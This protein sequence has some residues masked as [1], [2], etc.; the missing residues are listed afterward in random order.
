MKR[1]IRLV[2][3]WCAVMFVLVTWV[4]RDDL[5]ADETLVEHVTAFYK[6]KGVVPASKEALAVFERE[7]NL[8]PVALSFRKLQVSES[9]PG[10]VLII[11]TRGWIPMSESRHEFSVGGWT[12]TANKGSD[13]TG[14]PRGGS[15][16]GRP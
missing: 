1:I 7:M 9:R 4:K 16:S 8:P 5:Q 10:M 11:S 3:A 15:P 14:D 6:A 12:T 2:I 13:R